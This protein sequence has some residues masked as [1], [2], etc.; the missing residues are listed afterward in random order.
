VIV[1]L[2]PV[3]SLSEV[4]ARL[5]PALPPERRRAF[6]GAMLV[7][8]LRTCTGIPEIDRTV[9]ISRDP[10]IQHLAAACEVDAWA[11]PEGSGLNGAVNWATARAQ[12]E[13]AEATLVVTGDCPM[14]LASD[15]QGIIRAG[16]RAEVVLTPNADGTGT[17]AVFRR[18]A[19]AIP[20]AFGPGSLDRHRALCARAAI[21]PEM[22]ECPSLAL[23]IDTPEDLERLAESGSLA[24]SATFARAWL[25]KLHA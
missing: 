9:V 14:A 15:V 6:V 8:L 2:I 10:E 22:V 3:K 18:P 16:T 24:Q 11:E 12:D 21:V 5:A 25:R 23:D 13:G 4:K 17:N 19:G 20:I 7:D 1:T